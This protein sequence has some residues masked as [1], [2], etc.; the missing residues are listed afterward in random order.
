MKKIK[1]DYKG[2]KG[3]YSPRLILKAYKMEKDWLKSINVGEDELAPQL[4]F[5]IIE[6]D[7]I[8]DTKLVNREDVKTYISN[9]NEYYLDRVRD[10]EDILTDYN[11]E[12]VQKLV[13][14][15]NSI[16]NVNEGMWESPFTMTNAKKIADLL[17][18]PITYSEIVSDKGKKELWNVIGDDS[19]WDEM[20]DLAY[21]FPDND[22]RDGIA[23]FLKNWI[24][25]KKSFKDGAYDEKAANIIKDAILNINEDYDDDCEDIPEE[26]QKERYVTYFETQEGRQKYTIY[27]VYTDST[28][29]S[30]NELCDKRDNQ[31]GMYNSYKELKDALKERAEKIAAKQGWTV[32][33][34]E[35]LGEDDTY[36]RERNKFESIKEGFKIGDTVQLKRKNNKKGIVKSI[37]NGDKDKNDKDIKYLDVEFED[38]TKE[39]RPA[40]DFR[41]I[42]E[43]LNEGQSIKKWAQSMLPEI[44]KLLRKNGIPS[45]DY[46]V[47]GHVEIC[48]NAN[49]LVRKTDVEK[50][51]ELLPMAKENEYWDTNGNAASIRIEYDGLREFEKT[52]KS[53]NEEKE[54]NE[55]IKTEYA[56]ITFLKKYGFAT[57]EDLYNNIG[58]QVFV[59]DNA[60]KELLKQ[61]KIKFED[62]QGQDGINGWKLTEQI[63]EDLATLEKKMD[64]TEQDLEDMLM[65]LK[66]TTNESIFVK[67]N[68]SIKE[69]LDDVGI[70]THQ[71]KFT[72][73]DDDTVYLKSGA[74]ELRLTD[75]SYDIDK[76][77]LKE[78]IED[79]LETEVRYGFGT[80][81]DG[82]IN[83]NTVTGTEIVKFKYDT[84]KKEG[85]FEFNIFYEL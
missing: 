43:S 49:F 30:Y 34:I 66:D 48:P 81:F 40:S 17:S 28:D 63:E 9:D 20:E 51:L 41:K 15:W 27:H 12:P 45:K 79:N 23:T 8:M 3:I 72:V 4:M 61:D 85:E 58:A 5:F 53:K 84:D 69:A 19:F 74:Y 22:A 42:N 73:Y 82:D 52:L 29:D 60:V 35:N 18:K 32:K 62:G 56:I 6:N 80:I 70:D 39:G 14:N 36:Y 16:W 77:D 68:K 44:F 2:I 1:E 59:I 25:D 13:D 71:F 26:M 78:E 83:P 21:D 7:E 46:C 38:G 76:D 33:S 64:K 11:L 57:Q 55:D 10:S 65:N 75:I 24:K 31:L 37:F 54:M 47:L 50:V 67:L